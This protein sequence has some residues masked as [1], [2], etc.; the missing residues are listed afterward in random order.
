MAAGVRSGGEKKQY[1]RDELRERRWARTADSIERTA[2][3]LFAE[4]GFDGV[5]VEDIAYAAE[6]SARTFFRYF[7]TKDMVLLRDQHRRVDH[8][9]AALAAQPADEPVLSAVRSAFLDMAEGYQRDAETALLWAKIVTET[10]SVLPRFAGYQEAF[11]TSVTE[12]VASRLG[13]SD[14]DM[15]PAVIAGSMLSAS[16]AAYSRWLAGGAREH[17][18]ALVAE[19]LDLVEA[20]LYAAVDS[21]RRKRKSS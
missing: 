14:D 16:F 13:T 9:H 18:S 1:S 21:P 19:A 5:T 4:R 15:R 2:L 7:P 11:V 20:G 3:R 17:L 6:I 10:P 8:L 12:M